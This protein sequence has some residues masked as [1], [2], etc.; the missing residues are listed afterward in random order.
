[1]E[2]FFKL[3]YA[4]ISSRFSYKELLIII[5]TFQTIFISHNM[6]KIYEELNISHSLNY[7]WFFLMRDFELISLNAYK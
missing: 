4:N 7:A 2:G 5:L 6:S 3:Y 1:M